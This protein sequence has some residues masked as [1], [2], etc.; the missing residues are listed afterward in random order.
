M[1]KNWWKEAIV[2]QIYPRSFKDSNGDG[3]GD[4]QGI[5]SELDYLADLG[6][7]VI[8]LSPFYKSPNAD[9]GYD[10]SDYQAVM[11]EFGT[12]TDFD[13]LLR[14]IHQ[15]GMKLIIDLVVNHSSDEHFWFQESRKSKD[16]PYRDYYI[17]KTAS[18][19]E[20]GENIPPNDW[21]A[22]FSGDTWQWDATTQEYYLHL[23]AV[24]QP[25][26][27]WENPK[28][29]QEIYD[30]MHFWLKKGVNGFRMDVIPFL[31]KDQ[32]FPNYPEGRFGDLTFYANG[33]RIHE[34]LREM[35]ETV[36]QHYDCMT[37]GEG[38]GVSAEQANLYVGK[39]RRELDMIY[40]FDHA[41]PRYE[42]SF[43]APDPE[44][45][46]PQIKAIFAHW[47]TQL[48]EQGWQNVYFGNHDNPRIISRLGD[49]SVYHKQSATCIATALL[50]HRGTPG[51]YQGDE[52]GMTNCIF[53][54]ISEFNDLQVLNAYQ[55]LVI[56]K[57]A[58]KDL[59]M[60][61]TNRI[62]RDHARTPMQWQNTKNAGFTDGTS[63][64]PSARREGD[65]TW[66]KVNPNFDKINVKDARNTSNSIWHFYKKLIQFRKDNPVLVYGS[67]EDIA[68]S[69]AHIYAF[70]R[71]LNDEKLLIVCNFSADKQVFSMNFEVK[72]LLLSNYL[73]QNITYISQVL[74]IHREDNSKGVLDLQPY[75]ACI[76]Q[77][78]SPH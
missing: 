63:R 17:W 46:L 36:L 40:H 45:T 10:I 22:F 44:F 57:Q 51:I 54:D 53:N 61:A 4:L 38:F 60:V 48:G 64:T 65:T 42:H 56:D 62:A 50:T 25:D 34:F 19:N 23:F 73:E 59:F 15:R 68:P 14:G 12:M 55:A 5:I 69:E 1:T 3:I 76:F 33:P 72:K 30:M 6:V 16:N 58:N 28:L 20:N 43:L 67:F 18:Q 74:E 13:D 2:Y 8:W 77:L 37:I 78:S 41:V 75:E 24:K 29:R 31:S 52:I 47:D 70:T 11:P 32:T 35:H 49:T 71:T 26:L 21:Q 27:N 9:N 39:E 66:L 7:D